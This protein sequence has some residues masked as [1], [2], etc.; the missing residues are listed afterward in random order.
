MTLNSPAAFAYGG[1]IDGPANAIFSETMAQTFQHATAYELLN[2][3]ESYGIGA[4]LAAQI[5][6]SAM[7][8]MQVV[9]AR[10]EHYVA[11]GRRFVSWNDPSTPDDETMDTFMTIAF[12]FFAQAEN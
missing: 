3:A 8:T 4:D 11:Q 6:A 9:R 12:Q 2:Q 1:K 7:S 5:Q 10:Y